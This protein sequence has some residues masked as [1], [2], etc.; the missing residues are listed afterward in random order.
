MNGPFVLKI[1]RIN[2]SQ[3][4]NNTWRQTEVINQVIVSSLYLFS[5]SSVWF[6][7]CS[8]F[9]CFLPVSYLICCFPVFTSCIVV[10]SSWL[11][12]ILFWK[13]AS[14]IICPAL[15]SFTWPVLNCPSFCIPPCFLLCLCVTDVSSFSRFPWD[16]FWLLD[17]GCCFALVRFVWLFTCFDL[18]RLAQRTVSLCFFTTC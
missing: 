8:L 17:F 16:T 12:P 1:K 13:P 14:V 4:D 9:L 5:T 7:V 6:W 10:W 18:L 2:N 11:F 3:Y 15:I